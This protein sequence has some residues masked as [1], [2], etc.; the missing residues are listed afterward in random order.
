M[1][2][3]PVFMN[4][5]LWGT[6]IND[7]LFPVLEEIK[8]LGYHGVE[9]PIFDFGLEKWTRWRKKLDQLEL[10]R[11]AV[12][13]HG[14]ELSLIS[15]DISV[16]KQALDLLKK[17]VDSTEILGA[18]ILAGP[19]HSSLGVFS[20]N[21]PTKQE[22]NLAAR[23]LRELSN[24]AAKKDI[25]LALEYLNRFESYLV[26]SAAELASLVA[27]VNHPNCKIML[28]TF[29]A[30]IEEKSFA[31]AVEVL[32]DH[33][34]HVQLSENDRGTLGSGHVPIPEVLKA[35][36]RI[37]YSG[38]LS[39]EAFSEKLKAANIWRKT[40]ENENQLMQD[41][42]QYLKKTLVEIHGKEN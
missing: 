14:P 40:F 42:L 11:V 6:E 18:K 2:H 32:K 39:I 31:A 27:T 1:F 35:L 9:V 22:I 19:F 12:T 4:L 36:K 26:T 25:T 17:A 30:N 29:H 8:A 23:G 24:Y 37:N 21:A 13:I 28:D 15:P 20:G 38:V 5:L 33:L 41:S 3:P 7:D 16:Q 10:E 34:V